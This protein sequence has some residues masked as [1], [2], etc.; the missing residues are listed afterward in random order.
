MATIRISDNKKW[1]YIKSD[2]PTHDAKFW[3]GLEPIMGSVPESKKNGGLFT[4]SVAEFTHKDGRVWYREML[5][6]AFWKVN[7]YQH[8]ERVITDEDELYKDYFV[9]AGWTLK[10]DDAHAKKVQQRLKNAKTMLKD[11]QKSVK[12]YEA[13]VQR[14]EEE[15]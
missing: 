11:A 14:L 10:G 13:E 4:P 12:Y 15:L 2:N 3:L 1:Y 7:N 6:F 8:T 9:A 5:P